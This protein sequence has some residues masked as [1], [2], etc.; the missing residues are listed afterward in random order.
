MQ[1]VYPKEL[2]IIKD[3][4]KNIDT[5]NP[6]EEDI[7]KI[8]IQLCLNCEAPKC[9]GICDTINGLRSCLNGKRKKNKM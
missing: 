2:Y 9:D 6:T 5:S 3:I 1:I 8:E 7:E 4:I